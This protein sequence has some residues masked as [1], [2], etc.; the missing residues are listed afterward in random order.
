MALQI[1]LYGNDIWALRQGETNKLT[2]R[3]IFSGE[4]PCTHFLTTKEMKKIW[5]IW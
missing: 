1:L 5:I 2:I 3:L 4:Q